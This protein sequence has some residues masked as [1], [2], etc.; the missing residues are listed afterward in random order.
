MQWNE[1]ENSQ[2]FPRR[3]A[4]TVTV[5]ATPLPS[6]AGVQRNSAKD[7]RS[8]APTP[9]TVPRELSCAPPNRKRPPSIRRLEPDFLAPGTSASPSHTDVA[10][11]TVADATIRTRFVACTLLRTQQRIVSIPPFFANRSNDASKPDDFP[12]AA[13]FASVNET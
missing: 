6:S 4:G 1:Q 10:Y 7:K 2:P 8:A 13:P 3:A 9:R 5:T 12:I 11:G